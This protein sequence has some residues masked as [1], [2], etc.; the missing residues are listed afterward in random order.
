MRGWI[1]TGFIAFTFTFSHAQ[2]FECFLTESTYQHGLDLQF[3]SK[4]QH[5]ALPMEYASA[6][7]PELEGVH[8]EV[9]RKRIGT[10]MAARPKIDFLFRKKEER[11]YVV[12]ITD[13]PDMNAGLIFDGMS[14]C[15][16]AGVLGHEL[17]HILT[18]NEKNNWQ[19][20]LFGIKYIFKKKE[21]EAE[22]DIIAMQHGFG[23]QLI[24]Y[25]HY[26]HK[27]PHTNRKYLKNKKEHY[28]SANEMAKILLDI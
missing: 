18:Y 19:M 17:S 9:R 3:T 8:I 22:T 21:I 12:F 2:K 28:L 14:E 11:R 16:Q 27:S 26:I 5:F 10:L 25:T 24:E 13:D 15:A 6:H 4:T 23:D 20:L 1:L 7:F